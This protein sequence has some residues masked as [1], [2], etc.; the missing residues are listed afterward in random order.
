LNTSINICAFIFCNLA[1]GYDFHDKCNY[2]WRQDGV[3]WVVINIVIVNLISA[4]G[5]NPLHSWHQRHGNLVQCTKYSVV[6]IIGKHLWK[7]AVSRIGI[8]TLLKNNTGSKPIY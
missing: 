6:G 8:Q 3:L 4:R 5:H 2:S 1:E 7:Y